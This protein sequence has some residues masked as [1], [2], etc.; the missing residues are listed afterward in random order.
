MSGLH[1][2]YSTE[3]KLSDIFSDKDLMLMDINC[4]KPLKMINVEFKGS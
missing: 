4:F 1:S 3:T 2:G